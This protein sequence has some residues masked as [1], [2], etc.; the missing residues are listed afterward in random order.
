VGSVGS[1]SATK[2]FRAGTAPP[3]VAIAVLELIVV[4]RSGVFLMAPSLA[5]FL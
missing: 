2:V 5:Q 1:P 3:P 4:V